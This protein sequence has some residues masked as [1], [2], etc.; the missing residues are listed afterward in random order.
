MTNAS[1]VLIMND[2][3]ISTNM[4]KQQ[5]MELPIDLKCTHNK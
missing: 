3:G 1:Y 5:F 4:D 2:K